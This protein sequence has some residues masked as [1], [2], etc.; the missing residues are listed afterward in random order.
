MK[1]K[2]PVDMTNVKPTDDNFTQYL[3]QILDLIVTEMNGRLGI[4]DNVFSS[5]VQVTFNAANQ[6][7]AVPHTL[8]RI[9]GGFML[10]G[11]R[12][13]TTVYNGTSAN[14]PQILYVRAS[15]VTTAKLLVF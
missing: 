4:P 2:L 13:P 9:P 8:N 3:A 6:E 7:Q 5:I 14:T 1:I 15:A 12:D 10:V 11:S